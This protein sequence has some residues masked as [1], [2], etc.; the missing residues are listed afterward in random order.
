MNEPQ[1]IAAEKIALAILAGSGVDN[2]ALASPADLIP[3]SIGATATW[4]PASSTSV[5]SF[6]V[7][8]GQAM[9]WTYVTLYTCLA[10][11]T[12][13][14]VNYG[15]N[16]SA[17]AQLQVRAAASG[18]NFSPVTGAVLSQAIFNKPVLF[19][20]D[21]ETVPRIVLTPNGSTQAVDSLRV[22]AEAQAYLIPSGL[23]SA[24]RVHASRVS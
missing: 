23:A 18:A 19:V 2:C 13:A 15:F 11:E 10:D 14:G 7:P 9:L 22:E 20:F 21:S 5:F 16:Y 1:S 8:K 12:D 17:L 6:Q 24:F 3:L 4:P